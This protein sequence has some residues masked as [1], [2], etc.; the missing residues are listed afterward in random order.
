MCKH[1]FFTVDIIRNLVIFFFLQFCFKHA[2]ECVVLW[3]VS[4]QKHKRVLKVK[5]KLVN[6]YFRCRV[7]QSQI[8]NV[9]RCVVLQQYPC[10]LYRAI[11]REKG[12]L[13]QSAIAFLSCSASNFLTIISSSAIAN[14]PWKLALV[15]FYF[16]VTQL[17]STWSTNLLTSSMLFTVSFLLRQITVDLPVICVASVISSYNYIFVGWEINHS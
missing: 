17:M 6:V 4:L 3:P 5:P 14:S 16:W 1:V 12:I 7:W 11:R 2:F 13:L 15:V 9:I 8:L 10:E